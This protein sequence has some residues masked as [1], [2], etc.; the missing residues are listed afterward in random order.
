MAKK[1]VLFV[2][3]CMHL[4]SNTTCM[5]LYAKMNTR[6]TVNSI[7]ILQVRIISIY[8]YIYCLMETIT[9]IIISIIIIINIMLT[10]TTLLF[11]FIING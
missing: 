2:Y 8:M 4:Y 1:I 6:T 3:K 9:S 7:H 10:Q 11:L 5:H